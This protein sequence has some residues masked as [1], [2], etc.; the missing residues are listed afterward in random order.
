MEH[1]PKI[2]LKLNA[3]CMGRLKIWLDIPWLR[4]F[5]RLIIFKP[6]MNSVHVETHTHVYYVQLFY[7]ID[8]LALK[9]LVLQSY[10]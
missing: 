1:I 6:V 4:Q 2:G 8:Q 10:L 3:D 9:E 7:K 5:P